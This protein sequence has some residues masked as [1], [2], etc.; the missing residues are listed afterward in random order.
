MCDKEEKKDMTTTETI[1]KVSNKSIPSTRNHQ[2]SNAIQEVDLI[3][4]SLLPKKS[5][6]SFLKDLREE[7]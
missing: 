1:K 3:E 7:K 4:Q 6:R 5:A 2:I